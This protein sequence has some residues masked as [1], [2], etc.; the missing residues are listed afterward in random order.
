MH[1]AKALN[2]S[3][4][5]DFEPK[6]V[7]IIMLF[8]MLF[9]IRMVETQ[10]TAQVQ[11]VTRRAH[12]LPNVAVCREDRDVRSHGHAA[13]LDKKLVGFVEVNE[14]AGKDVPQEVPE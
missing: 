13:S 2:R 4:V 5:K 11:K 7:C 6:N 1:S 14:R 8:I 3:E 12:R 9:I 10:G